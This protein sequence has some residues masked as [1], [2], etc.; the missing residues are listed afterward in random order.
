MVEKS[1]AIPI[2]AALS[3]ILSRIEEVRN[4]PK[5]SK[6]AVAIWQVCPVKVYKTQND[7]QSGIFN[8]FELSKNPNQSKL[9]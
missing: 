1:V 8:K 6:Y 2:N 7:R 3:I 9:S 4:L 5:I